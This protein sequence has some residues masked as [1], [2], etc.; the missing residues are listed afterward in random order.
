MPANSFREGSWW[1][2]KLCP[3]KTALRVDA[4]ILCLENVPEFQKKGQVSLI[5]SGGTYW[6]IG[7]HAEGMVP[8]IPEIR[9]IAFWFCWLALKGVFR[10]DVAWSVLQV[11]S[12]DWDWD[13]PFQQFG[14][15]QTLEWYGF[16]LVE[17][18]VAADFETHNR[19]VRCKFKAASRNNRGSRYSHDFVRYYRKKVLKDGN[20][21][22]ESK[23]SRKSLVCEYDR[24]KKI[25][26]STPLWRLELRLQRHHLDR[27]SIYDLALDFHSWYFLRMPELVKFLRRAVEPGTWCISDQAIQWD[28]WGL[29]T[30]LQEA[31]W[32][33]Y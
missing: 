11:L 25:G 29:R 21:S 1:W 12:P 22:I 31:G 19:P 27:L 24:A 32:F 28:H 18:E 16:I 30:L 17:K 10:S 8:G 23:G 13:D 20:V 26:E 33:F 9:Q 5:N 2:G 3:D 14:Y 7:V 4:S 6:D 15:F